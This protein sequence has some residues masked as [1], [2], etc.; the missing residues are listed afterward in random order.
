MKFIIENLEL[1]TS[2]KEI[3]ARTLKLKDDEVEDFVK[4][5]IKAAANE[6]LR[7]ALK[8]SIP[9]RIETFRQ[10]RMYNLL[11]ECFSNAY[12]NELVVESFFGIFGKGRKLI[13]ETLYNYRDELTEI[14]NSSI[15]EILNNAE[16]TEEENY[17]TIIYKL[18]VKNPDI[19]KEL[20]L[21]IEREG[22]GKIKIS[23]SPKKEAGIYYC[24]QDTLDFL[25]EK[26]ANK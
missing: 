17:E 26:F 12:P 6:Y 21:I 2:E 23:A 8:I 25:K 7:M 5:M 15:S 24:R 18:E 19:I 1:S 3:V 13:K 22:I 20:N 16:E 9:A 11:K 14:F 4:K 10:E